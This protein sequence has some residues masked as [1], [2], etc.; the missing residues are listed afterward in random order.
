MNILL[1]KA[2]YNPE[3]AASQYLTDNLL[4]DFANEN[5]YMTL[6][7]PSPTR[8]VSDEVRRLYKNKKI[9]V[10]YDGKLKV[11]RFWMFKEGKNPFQRFFRYIISHIIHLIKGLK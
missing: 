8:G 7:V 3:S 11:Y 4:E 9:E 6:Y 5:V 10:K 1:L 2:Y